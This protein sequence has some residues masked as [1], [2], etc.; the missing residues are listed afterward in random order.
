MG[1]MAK[2]I[3]AIFF[4]FLKWVHTDFLLSVY[5]KAAEGGFYDQRIATEGKKCQEKH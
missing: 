3:S 1:G 4:S 5:S 2:K